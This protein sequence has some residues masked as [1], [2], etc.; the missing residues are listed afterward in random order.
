VVLAALAIG[1]AI[2]AGTRADQ[3]PGAPLRGVVGD[4]DLRSPEWPSPPALAGGDQLLHI[5]P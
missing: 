3:V 2:V 4:D 5:E 1:A